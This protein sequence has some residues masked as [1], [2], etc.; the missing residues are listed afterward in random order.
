MVKKKKKKKNNQ[1][2]IGWLIIVALLIGLGYWGYDYLTSPVYQSNKAIPN[3]A[4]LVFKANNPKSFWDALNYDNS[5]WNG[6]KK[7]K[8]IH[9]INKNIQRLD[10]LIMTDDEFWDIFED[11]ECYLSFHT[12]K[13]SVKTLFI[14]GMENAHQ[15]NSVH[16]FIKS[17]LSNQA[18]ISKNSYQNFNCYTVLDKT[19]KFYY[20]VTYGIFIASK[21][22]QLLHKS[23]NQLEGGNGLIVQSDFQEIETTCGKKVDANIFISNKKL[24]FLSTRFANNAPF[25]I[26]QNTKDLSLWNGLDMYVKPNTWSLNGYTSISDADLLILFQAQQPIEN[27]GILLLPKETKAFLQLGFSDAAHFFDNLLKNE[28]NVNLLKAVNQKYKVSLINDFQTFSGEEIYYAWLNNEPIFL[29]HLSNIEK[30]TSTLLRLSDTKSDYHAGNIIKL[31]STEFC[32]ALFGTNLFKI[33]PTNWCI[34]GEYL[35]LGESSEI[36][37]KVISSEHNITESTT[38]Q[39]MTENIVSHSNCSFYCDFSDNDLFFQK[40][41]SKRLWNLYKKN[42]EIVTDFNGFCVQFSA[43]S[44]LFYTNAIISYRN[45]NQNITEKEPETIAENLIEDTSNLSE[46]PLEKI[47]QQTNQESVEQD[48]EKEQTVSQNADKNQD[49]V[50]PGKMILRPYPV[51]DHTTNEKNFL[52]FDDK[53]NA[54]LIDKTGKIAWTKTLHD[55]PISDVYEI[56]FYANGKIQYLFNSK[57]YL[58]ALD[59]RGNWLPGYP[60]KL[61]NGSQNSIAVFDY[62]NKKDY[63]ILFVDKKGVIQNFTK[64][65]TPQSSWEHPNIPQKINHQ[66]QLCTNGDEK[67][68]IFPMDNGNVLITNQTGKVRMKIEKSFINSTRSN[69]YLNR[70]NSKGVLLTT[71]QKGTLIYIP[72]KGEVK[73]TS[74]GTF[75]DKHYFLYND[76]NNDGSNDFI[77]LD[78]KK[79]TVFDRLQNKILSYSFPS[80]P[81]NK[82]EIYFIDKQCYISVYVAT[83][84]K[85]YIFSKKGLLT[86]VSGTTYATIVKISKSGKAV[87]TIGNEKKLEFY[88]L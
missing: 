24:N 73:K 58:Y 47:S 61:T 78:G 13:D 67:Y 86:T 11:N 76:F 80:A 39:S 72:E 6:L 38:Y 37:S 81:T 50:L 21:S 35:L 69:F 32:N 3:D 44:G 43:S 19:S 15:E 46:T 17:F 56:D 30:A 26:L 82:P 62:S 2:F 49:I 64:D 57:Q 59:L 36:L 45:D 87:I 27:Q 53:N 40:N 63:R 8:S 54:C 4:F 88:D 9:Q 48:E 12:E 5:L 33:K 71:D 20:S 52:V 7:S 84:K 28:S 79:L 31:N 29:L 77:Y 18:D 25:S 16:R 34:F 55:Q 75:T 66:A 41:C 42:K 23:L 1:S 85:S 70:T 65:A 68:L 14:I 51:H 83:E 60:K 10:S 74:F 22:L